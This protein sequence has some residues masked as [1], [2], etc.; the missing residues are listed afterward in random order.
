MQHCAPGCRR[1]GAPPCTSHPPSSPS[2]K[3]PGHVR[4]QE[5]RTFPWPR[6]PRDPAGRGGLPTPDAKRALA[7]VT[8][9]PQVWE[10]GSAGRGR[11]CCSAPGGNGCVQVIYSAWQE[12]NSSK[13]KI[14]PKPKH[15]FQL[16][17][18]S[19]RSKS[20]G[21]QERCRLSVALGY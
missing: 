8:E 5:G 1:L 12:D 17:A 14:T 6:G 15:K 7:A 21:R 11:L 16:T 2:C 18:E 20:G 9:T 19:Q 3:S 10:W 13:L 4:E